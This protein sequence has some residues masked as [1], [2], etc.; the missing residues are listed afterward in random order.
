MKRILLFLLV[1]GSWGYGSEIASAEVRHPLVPWIPEESQPTPTRLRM[2]SQL[3]RTFEL[4][5]SPEFAEEGKLFSLAETLPEDPWIYWAGCHLWFPGESPRIDGQLARF[6][7]RGGIVWMEFC[8]EGSPLRSP[9][10]TEAYQRWRKTHGAIGE[11]MPITSEH[12]VLK[13]Y[14]LLNRWDLLVAEVRGRDRLLLIPNLLGRLLEEGGKFY[15]P[16]TE[17]LLRQALNLMMYTVTLDY[18]LDAIHLPYI[19]ERRKRHR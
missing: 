4:R 8:E 18:K 16:R 13:S 14:Y 5:S 6:L 9:S 19:L 15:T 3:L 10:W 1:M 2:V 7:K 12:V 17:T 11:L